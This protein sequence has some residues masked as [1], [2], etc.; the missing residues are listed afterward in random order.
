MSAAVIMYKNSLIKAFLLN[1]VPFFTF[2]KN[3]SS[4]E[5]K[6]SVTPSSYF[7]SVQLFRNETCSASSCRVSYS[8]QFLCVFDSCTVVPRDT[9]SLKYDLFEIRAVERAKFFFE[10]RG[11]ASYN[12]AHGPPVYCAWVT[13]AATFGGSAKNWFW[14]RVRGGGD[15]LYKWDKRD[16]ENVGESFTVRGKETPRKSCNWSCV[17]AI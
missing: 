8:L 13:V 12:A 6:N 11:R 17:G 7:F 15:S 9:S 10:I 2:T 5:W 3:I 4:I 16:L 14:G 1:L